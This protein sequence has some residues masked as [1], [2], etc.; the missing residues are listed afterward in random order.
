MGMGF[1]SQQST[2]TNIQNTSSEDELGSLKRQ[3]QQINERIQQLE[4]EKMTKGG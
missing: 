2:T 3:M 1:G 4:K